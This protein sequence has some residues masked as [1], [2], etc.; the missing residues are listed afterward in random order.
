[1]V[2]L[3]S[4]LLHAGAI[5]FDDRMFGRLVAKEYIAAQ[6]AGLNIE[7]TRESAGPPH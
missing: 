4:Q 3:N 2:G 6:D 7:L 5:K 1:M